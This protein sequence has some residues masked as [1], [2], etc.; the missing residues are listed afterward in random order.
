M[1]SS[2]VETAT[3]KID[4]ASRSGHIDALA[5]E[6]P[7]EIRLAWDA[8]QEEH[9]ARK[10]AKPRNGTTKTDKTLSITMRT[11]GQDLELALGFLLSE[12]IVQSRDDLDSYKHCGPAVRPDGT[13]NIVRIAIASGRAID[14]A[15]LERHF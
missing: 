13:S 7:L 10:L 6:E 4:G 14:L 15:R 3:V 12:G 5:I 11:P 8:S 1:S 9:F 2:I